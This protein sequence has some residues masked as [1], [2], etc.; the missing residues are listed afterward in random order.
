MC[1]GI[2]ET[3][4]CQHVQGDEAAGRRVTQ[5]GNRGA[6]RQEAPLKS[7]ANHALEFFLSNLSRCNAL[8]GRTDLIRRDGVLHREPP[9]TRG[10]STTTAVA[11]S[12]PP[13]LSAI[14]NSPEAT[15][16]H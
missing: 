12:W 13:R 4:A 11:L 14:D 16:P 2:T 3:Q 6:R 8:Q 1:G 5:Q 15:A 10:T 9:T 7:V